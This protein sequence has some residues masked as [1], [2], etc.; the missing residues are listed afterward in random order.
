VA[1][2]DHDLDAQAGGAVGEVLEVGDAGKAVGLV[3]FLELG[4]HPLG[5]DEV[6]EFGDD[7][8]LA[9][10]ADV[11]DLGACADADA[12]P[13]RFVGLTDP[14]IDHDATAREVGARAAGQQLVGRRL[15]PAL[16]HHQFDGVVEFGQVVGGHVGGHADGD[17]G[18]AV[19]E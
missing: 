17:A 15:R 1:V 19:E 6:G 18:G 5:T 11:L 16:L 10:P 14:V 2:A 12:A 3:E 9:A 4:D 7:D 8:G 13:T